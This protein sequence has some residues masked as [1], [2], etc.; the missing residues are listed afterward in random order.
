M[1]SGCR[2]IW[3]GNY[4]TDSSAGRDL[5][6]MPS[7]FGGFDSQSDHQA[8]VFLNPYFLIDVAAGE[9]GKQEVTAPWQ[10]FCFLWCV[11]TS[12]EGV[13]KSVGA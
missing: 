7:A 8:A 9:H 3:F 10:H 2:T 12:Q 11:G 1:R 6:M 4:W 13:N 5:G